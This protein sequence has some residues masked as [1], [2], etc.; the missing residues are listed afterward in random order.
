M[1]RGKSFIIVSLAGYL[2]LVSCS[3]TKSVPAGDKLYTGARVTISGA[4]TTREKHV[5]K[6]DLSGLTRPKPN[7]SFLGMRFKLAIY[8]LFRKSKPNSFFGKIR[9]KNGE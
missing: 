2:L 5:L 9:D 7:S 3:G 8:T 6:E 4:A 1:N